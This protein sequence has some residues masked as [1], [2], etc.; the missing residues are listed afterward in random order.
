MKT[1]TTTCGRAVIV[2]DDDYNRLASFQWYFGRYRGREYAFARPDGRKTIYMHT[3]LLGKVRGFEIDH[4]NGN[5][6]DNRRE[7]LRHVTPAQNQAN[8]RRTRGRSKFK[9]VTWDSIMNRWAARIYP[10]GKS[11]RLGRFKTEIE[12]AKAYDAAAVEVWGE[13]AATNADLFPGFDEQPHA[14]RFA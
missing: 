7:N 2:N 6:L 3:M 9:G 14:R 8:Q 13:Y 5:G 11:K 4:R 1:I 10:A 12:A